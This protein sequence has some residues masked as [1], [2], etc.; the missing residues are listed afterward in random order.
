MND[1][2]PPPPVESQPA[3]DE[4]NPILEEEPFFE[5]QGVIIPEFVNGEEQA[6][7]PQ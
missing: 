1:L 3:E 2:A 4:A 7:G 5:D 6:D